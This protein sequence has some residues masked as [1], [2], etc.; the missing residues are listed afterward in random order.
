MGVDSFGFTIR[1]IAAELDGETIGVAGVLH[2]YP[3]QAFSQM[4]DRLRR[5]P[6]TIMLAARKFREILQSYDV[7]YAVASREEKNADRFLTYVGFK[8]L[9]TTTSGR[10]YRWEFQPR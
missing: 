8:Y 2:G 1:G 3:T 10:T 4:D 5:Y 6:K 9:Q 7:A